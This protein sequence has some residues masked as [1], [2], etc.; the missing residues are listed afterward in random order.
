MQAALGPSGVGLFGASC[1]NHGK[2]DTASESL[3]RESVVVDV[4]GR[5]GA[6]AAAGNGAVAPPDQESVLQRVIERVTSLVGTVDPTGL[7]S[8]VEDDEFK[9]VFQ[10]RGG[11]IPS[12]T[13]DCTK[14]KF[15][16]AVEG[17]AASQEPPKTILWIIPAAMQPAGARKIY[18]VSLRFEGYGDPVIYVLQNAEAMLGSA[19]DGVAEV[20]VLREIAR[21][22][23]F[24]F[25][26]VYGVS[27]EFFKVN[28]EYKLKVYMELA[29][30]N[31]QLFDLWCVIDTPSAI[32]T[33]L[34][35]QI[36][37][38]RVA[39][40]DEYDKGLGFL[41]N[42]E[43]FHCDLKPENI[44]F[45][46]GE[47]RGIHIK[48]IDH[49]GIVSKTYIENLIRTKQMTPNWGTAGYRIEDIKLDSFDKWLFKVYFGRLITKLELLRLVEI[50]PVEKK[51]LAEGYI[52]G[53]A[54]YF[55]GLFT[56]AKA[57]AAAA[58]EAA[59]LCTPGGGGGGK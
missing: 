52:G 42:F 16:T 19:D 2:V 59:A 49:A 38:A 35:Q 39:L 15:P 17:A 50:Q 37:N 57:A 11:I 12:T 56:A 51:A 18:K 23:K 21:S 41:A 43:L 5:V 14:I 30:P 31:E 9:T 32:A 40:A 44:C 1:V 22:S 36:S 34:Y 6:G 25:A 58:A 29:S 45:V 26:C 20:K 3:L 28:K 4:A 54:T 48:F 8:V 10:M 27:V 13:H 55:N 7:L 47:D 33:E 46:L 24:F 53:G